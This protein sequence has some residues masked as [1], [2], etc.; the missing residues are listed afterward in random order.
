MVIKDKITI[1]INVQKIITRGKIKKIL[2]RNAIRTTENEKREYT[3]RPEGPRPYCRDFVKPTSRSTRIAL[4][5][6]L[7]PVDPDLLPE[8]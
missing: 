3:W 2:R 1:I 7:H 5:S 8:M 4:P 6:N